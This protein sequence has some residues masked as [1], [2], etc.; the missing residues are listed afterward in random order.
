MEDKSN[1]YIVAIVGIVAVLSIV[2]M[3]VSGRD[4]VM[5]NSVDDDN[6]GQL[7]APIV[8]DSTINDGTSPGTT[9]CI[10][11]DEG[12][13]QYFIRGKTYAGVYD[14]CKDNQTLLEGYCIN[15]KYSKNKEY[16]CPL[17]CENGACVT[18]TLNVKNCTML[19]LTTRIL[20]DANYRTP[21]AVT[22]T[23]IISYSEDIKQSSY[24]LAVSSCS[25]GHGEGN[26]YERNYYCYQPITGYYQ[27]YQLQ[28]K[29][30][31]CEYGCSN[32]HCLPEPTLTTE[33]YYNYQ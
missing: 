26:C 30:I 28:Y 20:A 7:I 14:R 4:R 10:D 23:C 12:P 3:I 32:G 16:K 21:I 9:G 18:T 19:G 24:D 29:K 31:R 13:F 33:Q 11:S 27:P 5:T 22:D 1:L 2:L 15:T 8:R 17:T 25:N 6:V